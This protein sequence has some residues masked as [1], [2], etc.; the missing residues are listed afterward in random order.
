MIS[1]MLQKGGLSENAGFCLLKRRT[2]SGFI[3]N[4]LNR[5]DHLAELGHSFA[6]GGVAFCQDA[7]DHVSFF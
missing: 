6:A 3:P 2:I 5:D 4:L 7:K 1:G